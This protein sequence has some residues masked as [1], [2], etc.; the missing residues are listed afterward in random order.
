MPHGLRRGG[1]A[2][3]QMTRPNGGPVS[4]WR[5]RVPFYE[6]DAMG[7]VH[8]AN[9]L[10]YMENARI[11]FLD[12]HDVPY[13]EYVESGRH[14]AVTRAELRYQ[15][16]AVFDD[17]IETAVWLEWIRGASL[18]MGYEIRRADDVLVIGATE[19]AMVDD[20]GRIVR[21]PRERRENMRALA[22]G[23]P[24]APGEGK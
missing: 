18:R 24:A 20:D 11:V 16:P 17:V 12:E 3:P 22:T 1:Y 5:H 13:R 23:A 10:H 4:I 8:H 7:V 2:P 21:I 6:T 9:Y 15:L 19:H 14:Y